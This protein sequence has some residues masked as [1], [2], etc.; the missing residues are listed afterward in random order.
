MCVRLRNSH[1]ISA[2]PRRAW[3]V[4]SSVY[5][6]SIV[7]QKIG[8]GYVKCVK[9]QKAHTCWDAVSSVVNLDALK[10]LGA[11]HLVKGTARFAKRASERSVEQRIKSSIWF[12]V[13]LVRL[14]IIEAKKDELFVVSSDWRACKCGFSSPK[15]SKTLVWLRYCGFIRLE[16][17]VQKRS[18]YHFD[19]G[20]SIAEL[21]CA[22]MLLLWERRKFL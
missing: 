13:S 22:L 12:S 15:R 20:S 17:R 19:W 4:I 3:S 5:K 9:E 21:F 8:E 1:L 16:E 2:P 11:V 10:R 6:R 7:H 14:R 18:A